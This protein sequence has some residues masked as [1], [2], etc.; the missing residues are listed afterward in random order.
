VCAWH[1][2][3]QALAAQGDTAEGI[4]Q[5]HRGMAA[6]QG[7]SA[8]QQQYFCVLLAEAYGQSGQVEAGLAL[9]ADALAHLHTTGRR[10]TASRLYR[11]QGELLLALSAEQQQAEAE[12]CFHHA[13][14]VARQQ[15]ARALEL[16]AVLSLSR[17]W[18]RQGKGADARALLADVYGWFT[19][20]F[21]TADLQEA[22][23]LLQELEDERGEGQ[24]GEREQKEMA[25]RT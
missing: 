16:R 17:L 4:A 5:M 25:K 22:K 9:L 24:K 11:A 6:V 15:Q 21:D 14:A 2:Q 23:A 10:I 19:E 12:R 13:L 20:G 3:G 8:T 1:Y 18:Q 7:T